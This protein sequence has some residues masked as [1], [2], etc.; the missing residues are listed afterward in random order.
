VLLLVQNLLDDVTGWGTHWCQ[1]VEANQRDIAVSLTG[2]SNMPQ[3]AVIYPADQEAP[4]SIAR[5]DNDI[6]KS[7]M[8]VFC[9]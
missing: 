6:D 5:L 2:L 3:H 4:S 7:S 1:E 9:C 8:M